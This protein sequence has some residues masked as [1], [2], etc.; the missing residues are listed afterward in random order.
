MSLT[1]LI[2]AIINITPYM[3]E[4]YCFSFGFAICA[5]ARVHWTLNK[6]IIQFINFSW[7][8]GYTLFTSC[9]GCYNVH[10]R[11]SYIHNGAHS[12]SQQYIFMCAL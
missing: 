12:Q 10:A 5:D 1:F 7:V 6:A 4:K 8:A 2:I 3:N 9:D 11:H